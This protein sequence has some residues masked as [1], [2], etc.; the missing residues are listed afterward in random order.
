MPQPDGAGWPVV[1]CLVEWQPDIQRHEV[2]QYFAQAAGGAVFGLALRGT[3]AAEGVDVRG[4]V[5]EPTARTALAFV[6]PDGNG[7]RSFL[8][9]HQGMADTLLTPDELDPE[10]IG[11]APIFHFGSV[12]LAAEPSRSSTTVAASMARE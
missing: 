2:S 8:F 1:V 5:A 3:L 7:G 4:F 11:H 10:L 12:T 9:Y 6:G